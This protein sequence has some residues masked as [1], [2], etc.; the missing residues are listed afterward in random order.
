M[1]GFRTFR[2]NSCD[3]RVDDSIVKGTI[4]EENWDTQESCELYVAAYD[5]E[6]MKAQCELRTRVEKIA[7]DLP[8][9]R[10]LR[11]SGHLV[12]LVL[13]GSLQNR[14]FVPGLSFIG[15]EPDVSSPS[16]SAP[17]RRLYSWAMRTTQGNSN[18][19]DGKFRTWVTTHNSWSHD[20]RN[21]LKMISIGIVSRTIR[22][23][24]MILAQLR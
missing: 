1:V 5:G 20:G 3:I 18:W 21:S 7:L 19:P 8:L 4:G 11:E 10:Q 24:F 16:I 12:S 22:L 9:V 13:V 17:I 23:Y 6:A 2:K 14:D 15:G